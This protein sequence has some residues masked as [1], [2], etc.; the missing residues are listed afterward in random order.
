MADGSQLE[1][2]R[3][4]LVLEF[5]HQSHDARF[6][7]TG[8]EQLDVGIVRS[9]LAGELLEYAIEFDAFEINDQSV[10]ILDRE[11]RELQSLAML[12]S[13]S[14]VVLCRPDPDGDNSLAL[15]DCR[16]PHRRNQYA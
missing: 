10:G 12:D 13:D 5:H 3:L 6:E 7:A 15:T 2:L 11:M 16:A 14:R 1:D 8:T 9:N 4:D